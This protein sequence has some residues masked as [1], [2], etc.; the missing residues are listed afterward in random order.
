MSLSA[1]TIL[2]ELDAVAAERA[3]R[4]ADPALAQRVAALKAYQQRRFERTHAD[5]LA[6]ARHGPAARFFL[7][8]LYGP[9]D[10]AERDTQFARIVP[11]LVRLFP[12][13][14]VDTVA[15]LAELHA[16][17]ERLDTLSATALTGPTCDRV[18]Y[19]HAWQA[20]GCAD[21]RRRQLTRVL[22]LGERLDRFTRHR[23]LRQSLRLMRGPARAAGLGALQGFLERGFDTF[24]QMQ[25][26]E[27]FL[28]Q[29]RQRE[30]ALIE[31]LFSP[32]AVARVTA[33]RPG[34][35]NA[36]GELP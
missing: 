17:T 30:G 32:D 27:A 6:D 36:I 33:A 29:I 10:F 14:I 5:L 2:A 21:E 26:A 34:V 25:G 7:A 23:W 13:E 12:P 22:E 9:Q 15:Q 18:A 16:L 8:D 3:R 11:A 35:A 4:A 20:T 24:A 1:D 19:V 31:A 28:A